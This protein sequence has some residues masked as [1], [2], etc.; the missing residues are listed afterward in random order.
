MHYKPYKLNTFLLCSQMFTKEPVTLNHVD[1]TL[2]LHLHKHRNF[3][4]ESKVLSKILQIVAQF[5]FTIHHCSISR[6]SK[7]PCKVN[8]S[9]RLLSARWNKSSVMRRRTS[10]TNFAGT[11]GRNS[12]SRSVYSHPPTLN[13]HK[14]PHSM[15]SLMWKSSIFFQKNR[16]IRGMT[17]GRRSVN[18][19]WKQRGSNA[20][21]LGSYDEKKNGQGN[22]L[23]CRW[24]ISGLRHLLKAEVVHLS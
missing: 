21:V 24:Q 16:G 3:H 8:R 12:M 1:D 7:G 9:S 10:R 11:P 19:L 20:I 6:P 2:H 5:W 17:M 23:L 18:D 22:N 13:T 14:Y 15:V 4:V